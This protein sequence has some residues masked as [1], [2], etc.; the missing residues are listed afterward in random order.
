MASW[1]SQIPLICIFMIMNHFHYS[2]FSPIY[3]VVNC[4]KAMRGRGNL[5]GDL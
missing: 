4:V 5:A 1:I 3:R 2:E